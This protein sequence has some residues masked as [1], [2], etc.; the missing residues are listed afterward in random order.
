[1]FYR[2]DYISK[3]SIRIEETPNLIMIDMNKMLIWPT[4][5]DM[6]AWY[7]IDVRPKI[8]DYNMYPTFFISSLL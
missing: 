6:L 5:D 4:L 2:K 7:N 1:M 8:N 3:S